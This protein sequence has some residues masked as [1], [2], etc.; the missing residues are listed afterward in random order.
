MSEI[1][2][3]VIVGAGPSGSTT[4]YYLAKQGL[5][6]LL[7]DK[8][9]FPRD[10][11]CGDGLTPRAL[12]ILDDMGLLDTL[13]EV[14]YRTSKLEIISTKGDSVSALFPKKE[15]LQDYLL[16]VP[17][18][19]LDNIILERALTG[20]ASFQAPVRV[21]GIEQ[22]NNSML[23]KGEQ[24]AK[25]ITFRTRMVIYAT[26]ANTKLLLNTGLL[27]KMPPMVLAVRTY[28]DGLKDI[29]DAGQC[30]FDNVPLPGYGWIFPVSS[31]SI[32]IGI[33]LFREGIASWWMPKTAHAAFDTFIKSPPIQELLEGG[34]QS[35]PLKG[36]PI[37]VDFARSPTYGERTMI[38]GEAAGLVNPITGE[39]IDY[40]MESGKMA[41]EHLTH[42]FDIGDFSHKQLAAF[43]K[44]LRQ[45]YQRLFELCDR[46]RLLYL[47]P[48][49]IN[50]MVR[51]IAR[52][53][54]LMD[55]FMDIAIENQNI[56][57][58][59]APGTIAKVIFEGMHGR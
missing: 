13:L 50:L 43:D 16:I 55:L 4:A 19:I 5:N 53:E 32:N 11:T 20:G 30:R 31:N 21:T 49:F 35:G 47:N 1:Y 45:R 12:H 34:K 52:N 27:K 8:F 29:F 59:L 9:N 57:R 23:V 17:R 26:G 42:M 14:G 36:F 10:K 51:A 39:G 38:I 7:L 44:Q 6:V 56:S 58:G 37:R 24:R 3:V 40:G 48:F 28:Y 22:E 46:L 2:D 33:G 41:A 25:T 54:D 15:S 18:I